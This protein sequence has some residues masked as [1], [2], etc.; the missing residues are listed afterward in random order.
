[1][2]W[3]PLDLYTNLWGWTLCGDWKVWWRELR[4]EG[5][6]W[7]AMQGRVEIKLWYIGD[8]WVTHNLMWCLWEWEEKSSGVM[9][10]LCSVWWKRMC[11]WLYVSS[12]HLDLHGRVPDSKRYLQAQNR[13]WS[14]CRRRDLRWRKLR[15]WRWMFLSRSY[16]DTF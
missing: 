7:L 12:P 15:W 6:M 3:R 10:W 1:M 4:A 11:S 16:W 13:R 2:L 9:W 8:T 14:P 5:W